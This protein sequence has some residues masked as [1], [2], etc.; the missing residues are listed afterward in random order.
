MMDK[1]FPP[2]QVSPE[3]GDNKIEK[4]QVLSGSMPDDK[5]SEEMATSMAMQGLT[6]LLRA[7][8]INKDVAPAITKAVGS[9]TKVLAKRRV[10]QLETETQIRR[11]DFAP[12][13]PV[14][15]MLGQTKSPLA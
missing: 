13:L 14:S 2:S 4:L 1:I 9:I 7:A 11:E 3:M 5:S 12:P 10:P 8:K 6:L 15:A